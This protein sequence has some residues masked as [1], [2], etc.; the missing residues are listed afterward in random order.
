MRH[1]MRLVRGARSPVVASLISIALILVIAVHV[2]AEDWPE[3]RGKGRLGVWNETGIVDRFPEGG[4]PVSWRTPINAGYSGPSV[5]DGR[6]FVT[7]SRRIKENQAIERA[8]ALD[9]RTGA[10][11]WTREWPT[12]YSGLQLVYAIGPRAT[13]TV[14][15]ERV[16]VLG[17]MGNLLALDV[18]TGS[19]L[20]QKDF[21]KDFNLEVP[22]WGVTSAPLVDGN[23]LICIVGGEPN[24]KVMALDKV[25][26][27][28]IWRALSSDWEA[29]YNQPIII[30]AAGVRQLIIWHPKAISSLDPATGNVYWEVD[31]V[32][33]MGMVIATPVRSGPYL[34]V[35]SQWGGALMLKLDET[36]PGGAVLWSGPGEQD[37]RWT[38][39]TPDTLNSVISTP[40]IQGEYL[41]GIDND[42]QLR[43]LS[44]ATG[45]LVWTSN[46]LLKE[47]AMYGTA[48]F[49]RNGDRYFINNDRG[50]L[51]MAKLSPEGFQEMG[52]TSLITP[53]HPYVRRRQL[54]NVLWSHPAYANRHIIIRNDSEIVRF[55]L[56]SGS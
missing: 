37:P 43:C 1:P 14:D 50:E 28:E 16:Y 26:G 35:T 52:R 17:G 2:R 47:H 31:H 19:V 23:R 7:D 22:A 15:G 4:L 5:A 6:V 41:Y 3:W 34:F 36:K 54:P 48:F 55:S 33:Q 51:V 11:L 13:P 24:A 30:E 40:A 49:V 12:D 46:A 9:E 25:T 39:D 27:K 18:K 20:W 38:K 8:M 21:V 44:V 42:G 32:V 56:A 10:I 53:T 45:K 29:G